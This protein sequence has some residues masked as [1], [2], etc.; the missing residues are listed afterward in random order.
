MTHV[1]QC[2]SKGFANRKGNRKTAM[3]AGC[4]EGGVGYRPSYCAA[5][6]C[7]LSREKATHFL[8]ISRWL[9]QGYGV[10]S[11]RVSFCHQAV[12]SWRLISISCGAWAQRAALS[13]ALLRSN[14]PPPTFF[15][16]SPPLSLPLVLRFPPSL[17]HSLSS[18]SSFLRS[19]SGDL[20]VGMGQEAWAGAGAAVRNS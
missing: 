1:S 4:R 20:S 5:R 18:S 17:S 19:Q 12:V 7:H 13:S 6:F 9:G 11:V 10:L 14:W 3:L 16:V 8:P 2:R 15:Y